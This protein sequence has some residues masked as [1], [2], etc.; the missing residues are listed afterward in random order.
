MDMEITKL[1]SDY[2]PMVLRR[3]RFLLRDEQ[4]ALDAMQEV[5]ASVLQKKNTLHFECVSSLLY[6]M[7]TN[8]CLNVIR[9]RKKTDSHETSEDIVEQIAHYDDEFERFELR[10][11]LDKIFSGHSVSTRSIAT[12]HYVDGLTLQETARLS[13]LSVSGVRKRLAAL[14][15]QLKFDKGCLHG[16]N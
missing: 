10:M 8:H 11:L 9:D 3:C 6:T 12:L 1:Y 7:A 16:S 14:S 2:G 4:M 15:N 5:F 13:G